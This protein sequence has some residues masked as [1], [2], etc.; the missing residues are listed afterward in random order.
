MRVYMLSDM[1]S[2]QKLRVYTA[3]EVKGLVKPSQGP[4]YHSRT[5]Q[6]QNEYTQERKEC[7][8]MPT[9]RVECTSGSLLYLYRDDKFEH[10]VFSV[11]SINCKR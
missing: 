4:F 5:K 8:H 7:M 3:S 9:G 11:L 6:T 1:R 10:T 2:G